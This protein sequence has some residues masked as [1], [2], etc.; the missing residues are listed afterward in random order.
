[1][2]LYLGEGM[3]CMK[4]SLKIEKSRARFRIQ[5]QMGAQ[6]SDAAGTSTLREPGQPATRLP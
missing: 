4:V 1:M 5:E 3:V 6:H 2:I